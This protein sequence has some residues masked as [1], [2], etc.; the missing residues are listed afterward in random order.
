M[1]LLTKTQLMHWIAEG[2]GHEAFSHD[3]LGNLDITLM[4]FKTVDIGMIPMVVDLKSLCDNIRQWR[5]YEWDRVLELDDF[6]WRRDPGILV[7]V[8]NGNH[9]LV[10][11]SHRALRREMEGEVDMLMWEFTRE[12]VVKQGKDW[13]ENHGVDW[14]DA[15][16]DGKIV[17]RTKT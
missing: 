6:S 17:K 4:R 10:D 15:I 8:G 13:T 9:V 2:M 11:G 12:T 14:G 3:E 7:R 5:V 16:V 1:G